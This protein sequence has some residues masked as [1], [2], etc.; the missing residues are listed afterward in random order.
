M[1]ECHIKIRVTDS[2]S[3]IEYTFTSVVTG[4]KVVIFL[5]IPKPTL[6]RL[7]LFVWHWLSWWDRWAT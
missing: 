6:L 5:T 1:A 3:E 7:K 4:I 2:I